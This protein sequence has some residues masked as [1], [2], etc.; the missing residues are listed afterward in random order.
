M[1]ERRWRIRTWTAATILGDPVVG[2]RENRRTRSLLAVPGRVEL[3][4]GRAG[5][6]SESRDVAVTGPRTR[7]PW[8][9]GAHV[10]FGLVRAEPRMTLHV[11]SHHR[12][13]GGQGTVDLAPVVLE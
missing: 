4:L 9:D 7:R 12:D 5:P 8:P 3:C 10:A 1:R 11:A 2:R 13:Q 6:A